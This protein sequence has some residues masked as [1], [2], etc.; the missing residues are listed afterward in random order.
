M[1]LNLEKDKPYIEPP[2]PFN[3]KVNN[4]KVSVWKRRCRQ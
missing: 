2:H 1:K 4:P 3:L